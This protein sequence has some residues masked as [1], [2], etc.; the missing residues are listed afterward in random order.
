MEVYI[1]GLC[2]YNL[3]YIVKKLLSTLKLNK[4]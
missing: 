1:M 2:S 3:M 4:H